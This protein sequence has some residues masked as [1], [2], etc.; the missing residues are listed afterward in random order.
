VQRNVY[1]VNFNLNKRADKGKTDCYIRTRE[2]I[3][4]ML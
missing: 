2:R 1:F 3:M 4:D